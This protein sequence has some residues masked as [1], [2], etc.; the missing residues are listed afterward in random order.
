MV[1]QEGL[2]LQVK[3]TLVVVAQHQQQYHKVV[4][5]VLVELVEMLLVMLLV[6]PAVQV[7]LHHTLEL[8]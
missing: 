2:E 8:Q 3:E 1:L 7:H 5:V 4:A 6:A